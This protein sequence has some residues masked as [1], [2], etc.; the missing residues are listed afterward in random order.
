MDK[1]ILQMASKMLDEY[2][3]ELSNHGCNDY[4]IE[5]TQENIE[6]IKDMIAKSDYPED[7]PDIWENKIHF[8]D[9][10]FCG[11]LQRELLR[12]VE[13]GTV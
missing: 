3:D 7:Q 4:D 2:N 6:L 11:Y 10:I 1:L 9:W 13:K 12:I 8:M 5:A